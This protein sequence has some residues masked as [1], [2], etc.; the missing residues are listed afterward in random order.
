LRCG[1]SEAQ[2]SIWPT[3]GPSRWPGIASGNGRERTAARARARTQAGRGCC[4][5]RRRSVI[6]E[7]AGLSMLRLLHGVDIATFADA[8]CMRDMRGAGTR[9][10][11]PAGTGP[12]TGV[13]VQVPDLKMCG[14]GKPASLVAMEGRVGRRTIGD[15]LSR[16]E[17]TWAG[18]NPG[19]RNGR[20]RITSQH[21]S[22]RISPGRAE[23]CCAAV[24][25]CSTTRVNCSLMTV[26]SPR[27]AFVRPT[28][29]PGR[30]A[31]S[32]ELGVTGERPASRGEQRYLRE[33][34]WWQPGLAAALASA[35]QYFSCPAGRCRRR[36]RHDNRAPDLDEALD[37]YWRA[38]ASIGMA[39]VRQSPRGLGVRQS[40]NQEP[41]SANSA[42]LRQCLSPDSRVSDAF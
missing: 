30:L 18:I 12:G 40:P 17:E 24:S 25:S 39:R 8:P 27:A 5:G 10:P 19:A 38:G 7:P 1:A 15:L 14:A 9:L 4:V 41:R 31:G 34:F 42:E 22:W 35:E 2:G 37:G 21:G 6:G 36:G 13:L 23:A 26:S 28:P 3:A 11:D 20:H 16:A 32:G 33:I 29:G